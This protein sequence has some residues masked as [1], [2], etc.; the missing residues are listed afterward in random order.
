MKNRKVAK[1]G[2]KPMSDV[3]NW[4]KVVKRI[5]ADR[6]IVSVVVSAFG[7]RFKS[8]E[9]ITD[10]LIQMAN[11]IISKQPWEHVWQ[12]ICQRHAEII[13]GLGLS[14]VLSDL[15]TDTRQDIL[16]NPYLDFIVSR[17]EYL[18]ARIMTEYLNLLDR[19]AHFLDAKD[20]VVFGMRGINHERSHELISKK[21][22][23]TGIVVIPGF[24]G[25]NASGKICIFSRG[26]SDLT[27]AIVACGLKVKTYENWTDV[28]GVHTAS[29]KFVSKTMS[30]EKTSYKYA[31]ILTSFGASVLHEDTVQYL[32]KYK[33]TIHIRDIDDPTALGTKIIPNYKDKNGVVGVA[34]L[35]DVT[36]FCTSKIVSSSTSGYGEKLFHIFSSS[37]IPY[38]FEL[39]GKGESSVIIE[40]KYLC[41]ASHNSKNEKRKCIEES[42]INLKGEI[43]YEIKPSS[44]NVFKNLA[45]ITT[46]GSNEGTLSEM[47]FALKAK[48]ISCPIQYRGPTGQAIVCVPNK[49]A[50][51][52]YQLIHDELFYK[53]TQQQLPK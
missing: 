44:I 21:A 30:I 51:V 2:G 36:A 50:M 45:A 4:K 15:L 12:K 33:I 32:E 29:P 53:D 35:Q 31:H 39:P 8:D 7:K 41:K 42:I 3:K 27:G 22:P 46:A 28:N 20:C 24:Y 52:A 26:G 6:L 16:E 17:G 18:S 23:K 49:D 37:K 47:Y 40:N 25:S 9:K 14:D 38:A 11:L 5:L 10:M 34:C 43:T 19:E 48:N 13:V 1:F